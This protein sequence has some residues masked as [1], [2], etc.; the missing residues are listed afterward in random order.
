MS[1][2]PPEAREGDYI[3]DHVDREL[4]P[5]RQADAD[6]EPLA[7]ALAGE[8]CALWLV[9]KDVATSAERVADYLNDWR[10]FDVEPSEVEL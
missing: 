5:V 2:A 7:W 3:W 10:G 4:R 1:D 8:D 9:P 6:W